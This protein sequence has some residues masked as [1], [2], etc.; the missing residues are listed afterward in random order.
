MVVAIPSTFAASPRYAGL[1]LSAEEYLAL[2]DDGH[3]YE[4]IDGVVILSPGP[5]FGHQD[6]RGHIEM[7]IRAYCEPRKLGWVASEVDIRLGPRLVYRP[8]LV[9]VSVEQSP[10]RPRAI[11]FAPRLVV[12]VL[13]PSNAVTDLSTKRD[14]YETAGVLE[15]W[16]VNPVSGD[17]R[18][19]R[20]ERGRYVVTE[21]AGAA[22]E[23]TAIPGFTLDLNGVRERA[24]E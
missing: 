13:S 21:A 10:K 18:V 16:I 5:S 14:D 4:L 20:L 8:D 7:Q 15:Y 2:P 11:D 22:L 17:V 24:G 19:H 23:S 3:R 6:I 9:F 1:R 12:E